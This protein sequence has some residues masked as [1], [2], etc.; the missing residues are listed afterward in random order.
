MANNYNE[1]SI[2]AFRSQF[3]EFK[4]VFEEED[5]VYSMLGEFAGYV[6]DVIYASQ[7]Y[8]KYLERVGE[9]MLVD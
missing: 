3:P 2:A 8:K 9:F 4:S 1:L 7:E 6:I 5:D